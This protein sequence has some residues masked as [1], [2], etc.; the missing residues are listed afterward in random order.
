VNAEDAEAFAKENQL[1][2]VE[3]S[4]KDHV[5][6]DEVFTIVAKQVLEKVTAGEIDV[7]VPVC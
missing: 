2:Y 6:V 3:C 1:K 7:K 5:N 4:S